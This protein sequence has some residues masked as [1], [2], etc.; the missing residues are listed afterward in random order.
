MNF[1]LQKHAAGALADTAADALVVIAA[2]DAPDT[3]LDPRVASLVSDAVASGDFVF[4]A[5]RTLYLHRPAGLKAA[6]LVVAA[7][8]GDTPKAFK[9]ALVAAL[10]V[11]KDLGARDV[12]VA[13]S[14]SL[15]AAHAEAAVAAAS[16]VR[17]VYR[18]TKPSAPKEGALARLTL[19][20]AVT[21]AS[22]CAA[23]R[24]HDAATATSRAPRSLSTPSAA[25]SAFLNALGVSPPAA[26]TTRR[27]AFRPAGRCR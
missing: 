9:K 5:G 18:H 25:T 1:R 26:A 22:A 27:A 15:S 19:L 12:A 7:A 24:L 23:V 6:R 8:G 11:L 16:D 21:A 13:A 4:K 20:V 2:G 17:Y 14:C 10:G 3:A